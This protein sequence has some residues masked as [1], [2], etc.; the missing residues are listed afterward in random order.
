MSLKFNKFENKDLN[1][2]IDTYTDGKDV[3]FKAR[4]IALALGYK[5]IDNA[6]RILDDSDYMT[7]Y[8]NFIDNTQKLFK[9]SRPPY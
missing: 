4:D 8:Q 6:I 7:K 3:W 5:D 1:I 2:S 9:S